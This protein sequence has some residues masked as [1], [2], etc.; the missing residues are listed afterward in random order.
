MEVK[1]AK[2]NKENFGYIFA[3]LEDIVSSQER[4]EKDFEKHME[5]ESE[6][7][8]KENNRLTRIEEQLS[9]SKAII[10]TLKTVGIL[11]F[12]IVSFNWDSVKE[13]WIGIFGSS[14]K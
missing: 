1:V 4:I 8:E 6:C 7:R 3:K 9:F 5:D 11:L 13:I 12:A 10:W 14:I 2:T